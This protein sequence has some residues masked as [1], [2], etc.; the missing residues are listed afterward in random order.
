M[1]RDEIMKFNEPLKEITLA[2]RRYIMNG[3]FVYGSFERGDMYIKKED[4]S[5][6]FDKYDYMLFGLHSN[7]D[8][9]MAGFCRK[10]RLRNLTTMFKDRGFKTMLVAEVVR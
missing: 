1:K 10:S 5:R 4:L 8:I 2:D 3:T 6:D 7:G 9:M